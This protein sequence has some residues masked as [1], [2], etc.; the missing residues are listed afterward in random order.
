[1]M[2]PR[3]ISL[4]KIGEMFLFIIFVALCILFVVAFCSV[5]PGPIGPETN[6]DLPGP[7]YAGHNKANSEEQP[8]STPA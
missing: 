2:T 3:R 8:H 1:M 4:L 5:K 7:D 6:H